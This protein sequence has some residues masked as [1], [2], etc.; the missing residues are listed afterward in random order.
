ML[1][2]SKEGAGL[3]G[4]KKGWRRDLEDCWREPQAPTNCVESHPY[5]FGRDWAG[6]AKNPFRFGSA[7]PIAN[8]PAQSPVESAPMA[9][10]YEDIADLI[11]DPVAQLLLGGRVQTL[12]EAE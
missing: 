4:K 12:R 1:H 9:P 3:L 6:K 7:V 11:N 10:E 2:G 8:L 5:Q